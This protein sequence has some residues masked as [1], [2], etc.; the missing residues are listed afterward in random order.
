MIRM[1][2]AA[3]R[4]FPEREHFLASRKSGESALT[5]WWQVR[6]ELARTD[7]TSSAELSRAGL[8]V[9]KATSTTSVTACSGQRLAPSR[10]KRRRPARAPA[11]TVH[12]GSS[13]RYCTSSVTYKEIHCYTMTISKEGNRWIKAHP[14]KIT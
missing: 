3:I 13:R 12:R 11:F 8:S 2:L 6:A 10:A 1:A 4:V 9:E 5:W 7:S 14:H